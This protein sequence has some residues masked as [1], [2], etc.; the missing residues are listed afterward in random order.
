M[1]KRMIFVGVMAVM[2]MGLKAQ[3][4]VVLRRGKS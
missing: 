4:K 2:A 1:K 3:D